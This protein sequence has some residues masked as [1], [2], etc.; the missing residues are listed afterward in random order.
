MAFGMDLGQIRAWLRW[1]TEQRY[2]TNLTIK[3]II[4][5]SCHSCYYFKTR[6]KNC[7]GSSWY[8]HCP[9]LVNLN[10]GAIPSILKQYLGLISS[11]KRT[12][13]A[14]RLYSLKLSKF[15]ISIK[16]LL[17]NTVTTQNMLS[18]ND[19]VS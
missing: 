16:V 1:W 7:P 9:G 2:P 10:L 5:Y 18:K 19:T 3:V 8:S 14:Q 4:I 6:I 12:F 17:K 13:K 15:R 11:F